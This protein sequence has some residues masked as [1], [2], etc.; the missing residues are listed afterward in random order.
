LGINET[1]DKGKR[2][3]TVFH[4]RNERSLLYSTTRKVYAFP[5]EP[6]VEELIGPGP[7]NAYSLG[8]DG[9]AAQLCK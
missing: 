1:T 3:A 4:P 9:Q 8:T 7:K 5:M 6:P 2:A